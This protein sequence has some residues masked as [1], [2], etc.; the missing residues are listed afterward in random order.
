M[1]CSRNWLEWCDTGR[2][3]FQEELSSR[4]EEYRRELESRR[5]QYEEEVDAVKKRFQEL[6]QTEQL[7]AKT[8]KM[9]PQCKAPIYKVKKYPIYLYYFDDSYLQNISI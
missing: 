1:T 5:K 2:R 7:L 9:C 6:Q 3:R 8:F 4:D